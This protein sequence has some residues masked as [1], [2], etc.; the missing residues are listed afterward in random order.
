MLLYL[1]LHY[2]C[3][4]VLAKLAV[5]GNIQKNVGKRFHNGRTSGVKK[6]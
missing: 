1:F 2:I 4:K 6:L 3:I 5:F